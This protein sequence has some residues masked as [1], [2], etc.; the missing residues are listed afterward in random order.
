ME[1]VRY[2]YTDWKQVHVPSGEEEHYDRGAVSIVTE[3]HYD[4]GAVSIMIG[5]CKYCDRGA[6]SIVIGGL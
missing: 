3:Q 5:G 4:R 6:V 2:E 1:V